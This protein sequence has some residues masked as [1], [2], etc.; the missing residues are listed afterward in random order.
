MAWADLDRRW[1]D[2]FINILHTTA[3]MSKDANTKVGCLIIDTKNKVVV[4]SGWNDLPRGVKHTPERNSRPLKYLFTSHA[5]QSCLTNA[6]R[7]NACVTGHTMLTTLA[8][9]PQCSCSVVNSSL[10]EVVTPEPDLTHITYG[11]DFKYSIEIMQ[12]GG[13]A[14]CYDNSL[15]LPAE[16][17]KLI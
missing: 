9:C 15:L 13:V 16:V 1:K 12:E 7:L 10:A 3:A 17:K 2:Y 5:E 4:S 14:W 11:Q 6:L 8:C